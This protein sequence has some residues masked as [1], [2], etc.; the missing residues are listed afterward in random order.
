MARGSGAQA[1]RLASWTV[2]SVLSSVR[3]AYVEQRW[4]PGWRTCRTAALAASF[5]GQLDAEAG[6]GQL[7]QHLPR[8]LQRRDLGGATAMV[9]RW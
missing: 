6:D 5:C 7:E 2:A 4:L 3:R 9:V 1:S 8:F